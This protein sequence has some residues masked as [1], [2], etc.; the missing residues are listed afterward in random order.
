MKHPIHHGVDLLGD[1][2]HGRGDER[3]GV[4]RVDVEQLAQ[5]LDFKRLADG[6][7]IV[8][9]ALQVLA[10]GSQERLGIGNRARGGGKRRIGLAEHAAQP[11]Y[12]GPE[13]A[14]GTRKPRKRQGQV[15]G[16]RAHLGHDLARDPV[17]S[18]RHIPGDALDGA[19]D[20]GYAL[21]DVDDDAVDQ[22]D[23]H[24]QA[25]GGHLEFRIALGGFLH[26]LEL[27]F[28][29]FQVGR[30]LVDRRGS[31]A[32]HLRDGR[33]SVENGFGQLALEGIGLGAQAVQLVACVIE[34]RGDDR[35]L[36][37]GHSQ[38]IAGPARRLAPPR[39][40]A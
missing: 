15:V 31:L 35:Q 1:D 18:V 37:V 6:P 17:R 29:S 7:D 3:A 11:L 13:L 34:R 39:D 21:V 25:H 2:L 32:R 33:R 38:G 30:G 28:R 12:F 9:R 19:V 5:L 22:G 24:F 23:D 36:V 16:G 8:D 4:F 10:D 20:F 26:G 14:D 40:G 27:R